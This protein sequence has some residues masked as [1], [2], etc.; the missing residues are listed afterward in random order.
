MYIYI[1]VSLSKNLLC[2][3]REKQDLKII[4]CIAG[5]FRKVFI[6][7][8]FERASLFENKLPGQAVLRK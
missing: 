3:A 6:F 2:S 5:Y 8:Y 4:Y 1:C 7:G